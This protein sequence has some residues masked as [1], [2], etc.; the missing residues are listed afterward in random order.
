MTLHTKKNQVTTGVSTIAWVPEQNAST[1]LRSVTPKCHYG[2]MKW[3]NCNQQHSTCIPTQWHEV[4]KKK[5]HLSN[6][7]RDSSTLLST[8]LLQPPISRS[9]T[10]LFAAETEKHCQRYIRLVP[11]RLSMLYQLSW[12][13][14]NYTISFVQRTC[15]LTVTKQESAFEMFTPL[16]AHQPMTSCKNK[17]L[18]QFKMESIQAGCTLGNA[19]LL[20]TI[21]YK[22]CLLDYWS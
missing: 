14:C 22:A 20:A 10:H 4:A 2:T 17:L 1:R 16:N 15:T 12:R 21:C 9:K 7:T 18:W 11:G 19:K 6:D 5:N 3:V 13:N 8:K